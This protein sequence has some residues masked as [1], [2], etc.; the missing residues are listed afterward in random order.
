MPQLLSD[1]KFLGVEPPPTG[2][3]DKG[4]A[5]V[6][7]LFSKAP[8][9]KGLLSDVEFLGEEKP[10]EAQKEPLTT[11]AADVG[12]RAVS[13]AAAT[14]DLILG[15]PASLASK[16]MNV[17]ARA[18]A[19]ATGE[20]RE[21]QA[22][23]GQLAEHLGPLEG[24]KTPLQSLAKAVIGAEPWDQSIVSDAMEK[25]NVAAEKLTGGALRK[26][27]A[28]LLVGTLMD[29]MGIKGL[30]AGAKMLSEKPA[31]K[32]GEGVRGTYVE[33]ELPPTEVPPEAAPFRQEVP[34]PPT[35]A[36][37]AATTKARK[38]DV[39]AAFKD[40][41]TADHLQFKANESMESRSQ[42]LVDEA[43]K[44]GRTVNAPDWADVAKDAYEIS[45][46][47]GMYRSPEEMI[48]LR[49]YNRRAFA[50]QAG[51]VD[52]EMLPFV[53]SAVT[54][55]TAGGLAV[56]K[57]L[58]GLQ[59]QSAAEEKKAKDLEWE[60]EHPKRFDTIPGGDRKQPDDW[61]ILAGGGAL[62]G[63]AIGAIKSKG[64]ERFIKA[65]E[66]EARIAQL[67]GSQRSFIDSAAA[68]KE[69]LG[70]TTIKLPERKAL[71]DSIKSDQAVVNKIASEIAGVK[72]LAETPKAAV[73]DLK[74]AAADLGLDE[75][76]SVDR[77]TALKIA[78]VGGA[79]AAGAVLDEDNPT[80][81]A[82]LGAALAGVAATKG[83]R[84]FAADVAK[85]ADYTLGTVSTRLRNISE[86]FLRHARAFEQN[87][88]QRTHQAIQRG[89]PFLVTL[90]KL[91]AAERGELSRALLSNNES[92]IQRILRASAPEGLAQW[93]ELRGTL[94]D[95]GNELQTSGTLTKLREDYFPR[96]VKDA[97]GLLKTLDKEVRNRL[98]ER[99]LKEEKRSVKVQGRGLT[100]LEKSLIINEE[101]RKSASMSGRPGF[102]RERGVPEV[103]P[104]L[105]QFYASPTESFHS[106]VRNATF[107]LE[108]AK[109]FG[110]D[111]A[112]VKQGGVSYVDLDT[113]IGNVVRREFEAGK[114]TRDQIPEL[115]SILR[116]RFGAGEQ[117]ARGWV[118]DVRNLANVGLLGNAFSAASQ[119]GDAIMAPFHADLRGTVAAVAQKIRGTQRIAAKD[120]G[121][122]D[123]LSEEF[124]STRGTAKALNTAFHWS[125]FT[126][127][128]LFG[129]DTVLNASLNRFQRLAQAQ[130]G[131]AKLMKEHGAAFTGDMAQLVQDLQ[132]KKMSPLVQ[133]LLFN[134]L[135]DAQ[136]ITKLEVPQ[137]Y[138]DMPNG[139]IVY[140]LKT[141][142][143]KQMDIARV[144]GYN[145]IKKG[146][147][148]EGTK[149][150]VAYGTLLG[151][152]GATTDMVKDWL[153]GRPFDSKWED[154]PLNAIKTF[155]WSQY[156]LDMAK[157]GHPAKAVANIV[158]P[159]YQ[160]LDDMV[161]ADPKIWNYLPIVGK[162]IYPHTEAGELA[163]A[164]RAKRLR[165]EDNPVLQAEK[166]RKRLLKERRMKNPVW[167]NYYLRRA[168]GE[169]PERPE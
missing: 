59:D 10:V 98:D 147:V 162:L 89:D 22:Q 58:K 46:K 109:F 90:N 104:E 113:S 25:V 44:T 74:K 8:P 57:Y 116:S 154:I 56:Y 65:P 47:P 28:A 117:G 9:P 125:M 30:K 140:M 84:A 111:L 101:L 81:G 13:L 77:K 62:A 123:H 103:T 48:R 7:G 133:E 115:S 64:G 94:R 157:G 149:N 122:V 82:L 15:A 166:E 45:Q 164:K 119:L 93:K 33:E 78:A 23:A 100:E 138:L 76:G 73:V 80:Q 52:P 11:L 83:G 55:G 108:K 54:V 97:E 155:G 153:L 106:Y 69:K 36:E 20:S 1:S 161:R 85:T 146:N 53:L 88:L 150:L 120:Y 144:R 87:V 61:T 60:T 37:R 163:E 19:M 156:T 68:A 165:E 43:M 136:P 18:F 91:P 139:R 21:I 102:T 26:E 27:D 24:L 16:F 105:E 14:G 75:A 63:A 5:A 67:E 95:I 134:K 92:A 131:Q 124:V 42:T 112:R 168:R 41:D 160:M 96:I 167:K 129:K 51:K 99:L 121:L 50:D 118:Q 2:L 34:T 4:V 169:N 142:M 72:A 12:K 70:D 159:P 31:A 132:G 39:R 114:V 110:R 17:G 158:A 35:A 40:V 127:V 32:T 86:P 71:Q 66:L 151:L 107:E 3:V 128:D 79:A 38:A 49:E 126:G 141:F 137:A 135:S 6:K 145:E 130:S 148:A 152:S 29:S 143:L